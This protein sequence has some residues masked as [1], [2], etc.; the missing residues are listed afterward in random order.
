MKSRTL[1]DDIRSF[2]CP[3]QQDIAEWQALSREDQLRTLRRVLE[4]PDAKA[5]SPHSL[6]DILDQA[7][8]QAS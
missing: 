2:A 7:R 1:N 3:D 5:V 4:H 8:S 6:D